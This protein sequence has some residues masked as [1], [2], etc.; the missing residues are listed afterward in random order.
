M[1]QV[2]RQKYLSVSRDQ[3][4]VLLRELDP[5]G[6]ASHPNG[7][8]HIDGYDKL[9]PFGFCISGCIDGYSRRVMFLEVAASNNDP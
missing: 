1:T 6:C 9:K 4:M 3:V 5:E 8:W 7:T 2:L